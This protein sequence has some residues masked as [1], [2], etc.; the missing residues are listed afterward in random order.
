MY[1]L[2]FVVNVAIVL[3]LICKT[4]MMV[5]CCYGFCDGSP[6]HLYDQD[7]ATILP[8]IL[9]YLYYVAELLSVFRVCCSIKYD[10]KST[11]HMTNYKTMDW[12]KNTST[13]QRANTKTRK[14]RNAPAKKRVG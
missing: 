13:Q 11:N 2:D 6:S 8:W 12:Q 3:R 14:P 5:R 10:N 9:C 1:V 4:K 7:V